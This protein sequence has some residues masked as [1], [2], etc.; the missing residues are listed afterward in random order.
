MVREV[1]FSRNSLDK[2]VRASNPRV[3]V[4]VSSFVPKPFT[5]FQWV[6]QDGVE[7]LEAKIALLA[8]RLRLR[9]VSFNWHDPSLSF[10]EAVLARGDRKLGRLLKKA[11]EKG[12]KFDGWSEHFKL[13]LWSESFAEAGVDPR[14]YANR[15][16][17]DDEI[18]PWEHI[19]V[20][21]SRDFLLSEYKKALCGKTSPD[22]RTLC[23]A[24]GIQ[25]IVK[26]VC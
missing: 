13:N 14:F 3:T 25:D 15:V 2:N 12:C 11:W 5:P 1:K 4:S 26:G 18:F 23:S 19:D 8:K 17:S 9:G 24:C 16:R 7:Q 20:G 22:C 21:V 6:A 10:I